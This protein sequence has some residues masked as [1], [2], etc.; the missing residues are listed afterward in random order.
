MSAS[1]DGEYGDYIRHLS[2]LNTTLT[3]LGG[4]SFTA[5]TILI[6]RLQN[7][8]SLQSQI[9]LLFFTLIFDLFIFLLQYNTIDLIRF[10]RKI[11]PYTKANHAFNV[12]YF[13]G[14]ILFGF[15]AVALFLLWNLTYLA[16]AST[17]GSLAL[18]FAPYFYI[19]RPFQR[20]RK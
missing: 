5:I 10:C 8:S 7:P 9:V 17:I 19:W 18:C 1:G 4:F 12:L 14:G 15:S 11:P 6:T 16:F 13:I 3:L 20:M 2:N